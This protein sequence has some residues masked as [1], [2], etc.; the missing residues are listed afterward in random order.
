MMQI[1]SVICAALLLVGASAPL[2]AQDAPRAKAGL[3]TCQTSASLGLIVGSHQRLRC[4]FVPD[5]G[6]HP[7]F[8]SGHVGRIGLDVGVRAAGVLAWAVF[9]PTN[10]YHHGALAGT[11]VGASGDISLGV[12]VGAKVLVGG[13]HRSIALQPVSVEGQLGINVA[14]GVSSLTL[15]AH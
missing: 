8:Y 3:L 10:G 12:G 4:R 5:S 15:Q 11:Y 7:E 9:A 2:A 1:R 13:S 6:G 14:L